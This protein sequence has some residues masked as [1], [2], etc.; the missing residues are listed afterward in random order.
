MYDEVYKAMVECGEAN[1]E[2]DGPI[3]LES[4]GSIA[5]TWDTK[6]RTSGMVG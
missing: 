4:N 1:V 2:T 5:K 3:Y 6:C